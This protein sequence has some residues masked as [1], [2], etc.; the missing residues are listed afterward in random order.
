MQSMLGKLVE[1]E[2]RKGRTQTSSDRK[3]VSDPIQHKACT[4]VGIE[5]FVNNTK[6]FGMEN[7]LSFYG[8]LKSRTED[9]V[10]KEID[11]HG[12]NC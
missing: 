7:I 4:S 2:T 8:T 10:V 9:F 11:R 1:I 6:T 12:V 3:Y 5:H